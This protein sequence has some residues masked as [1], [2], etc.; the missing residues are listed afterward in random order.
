MSKLS[1]LVTVYRLLKKNAY[2]KGI[3]IMCQ[4][5]NTFSNRYK[6]DICNYL[7]IHSYMVRILIYLCFRLWL[8]AEVNLHEFITIVV[9]KDL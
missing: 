7:P 3:V 5:R 1:N 8:L 4:I 6:S 9:K 2:L